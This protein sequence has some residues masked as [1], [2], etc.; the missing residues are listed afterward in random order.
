MKNR[1]IDDPYAEVIDA[2]NKN[3]V[4]YVVVGMSGINYYAVD[5]KGT[6]ATQDFDIFINPTIGNVKKAISIFKEL[7]YSLA[8]KEG[9][10]KDGAIKKTVAV[11]K[12]IS[13]TDPYG[14]MFEILLA[15]SGYRF[16][17]MEKGAAIF[18]VERIPVKVAKLR[19]LLQSKKAAGRP[20]DKFFLKRYEIFL[21]G[22]PKCGK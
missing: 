5:A 19:K 15:V 17:Q 22:A 9:E 16:D 12:T 6:F 18:L 3:G 8:V 20:K 13:A 4:K 1:K 2:F 7:G 10:L 11:K 21:K 14:I